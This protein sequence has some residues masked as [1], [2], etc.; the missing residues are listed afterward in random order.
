MITGNKIV[1]IVDDSPIIIERLKT[2]LEDL[3]NVQTILHAGTY[4]NALPILA[5]DNPDIVI[6][7]INL[8]DKSGIELLRY[9]KKNQAEVTVIMLSNQAGDYYRNLCQLCGAQYFIDKST[10]FEQ[11]PGIILSLH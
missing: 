6:L 3:A 7:D 8:P 9:I 4:A 10:E 5:K 1:L 11:V 2:M